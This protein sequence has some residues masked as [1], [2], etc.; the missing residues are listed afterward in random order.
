[1]IAI[2]LTK[3]KEHRKTKKIRKIKAVKAEELKAA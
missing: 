2:N 3:Q 1:L